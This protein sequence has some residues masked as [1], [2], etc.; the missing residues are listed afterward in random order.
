MKLEHR[1]RF[2]VVLVCFFLSGLAAL[3]Y[4][5]VWSRQFAFVFGTS[6]LA[7]ATVLAAYMAGL[8]VGAAAA[9]RWLRR[10]R[11]PVLVYGVLELGIAVAALLVPLG[12]SLS[13]ALSKAVL[14]GLEDPAAAEGLTMA[15][16]YLA[17]SFAI[18]LLPT[19][20]MGAT[21]PILARSVVERDEQVG[22]RIGTLYAVNTLGAVFGTI[23]AGFFLLP[24]V[25][26]RMT[27]WIGVAVNVLV[28]LV[29]AFGLR[30]PKSASESDA[31]ATKASSPRSG[32]GAGRWVLPLMLMSGVVSF[33][34]E[35]LWTRLLGHILGGSVYAF[36]TMLA[37][38]LVGI[39]VGSAVGSRVATRSEH[40]YRWFSVVQLAIGACAYVAYRMVDHLPDVAVNL[41]A[42]SRAGLFANAALCAVVLL[43]ATLCIGA[44]FP[45]AVRTLART[46]DEAGEASA[47]VYSWNTVGAILGAVGAGFVLLPALG[48]RGAVVA[49]VALNLILAGIA[50]LL[51]AP[52]ANR[53]LV[54]AGVALLALLVVRAETPWKILHYKPLSDVAPT[55]ADARGAN[56]TR[57]AVGRGATVLLLE[58]T[59]EWELR[60]N[61]N[62]EAGILAPGHFT[63]ARSAY[64]LSGL[65]VLARPKTRSMLVIGLGG[66]TL[67]EALPRSLES[68]DVIELE[69]EILEANRALQSRRQIDPLAD[70]R[71]RVFL[72]D[73]RGAL[74]LTT[75]RYDAIV[76]QPS[77]PWTAG[78]AHLYTREFFELAREHLSEDGVLLQWIGAGF[79]DKELLQ[80]LVATLLDVFPNVRA[81]RPSNGPSVL[82]LASAKPLPVERTAAEAIA[83]SPKEFLLRSVRRPEDVGAMLVFDEEGARRFAAGA[84][85]N[86]D[87]E[88]ILQTRSPRILRAPL[89]L[90]GLNRLF[91]TM[92]PFS[93]LSEERV[94]DEWDA[95][96]LH[97]MAML[98]GRKAAALLIASRLSEHE[99]LIVQARGLLRRF[100]G[101]ESARLLGQALTLAPDAYAAK[102]LLARAMKLSKPSVE[103]IRTLEQLVASLPPEAQAVLNGMHRR[104]RGEW[105]AIE[106]SDSDLEAVRVTDPLHDIA[107]RL[108]VLWRLEK[109]DAALASEAL[110]MI[111]EAMPF[112]GSPFPD[113][114]PDALIRIRLF[115]TLGE[116]DTSLSLLR[117]AATAPGRTA[118]AYFR[119]IARLLDVVPPTAERRDGISEVRSVL[120][121]KLAPTR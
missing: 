15:L 119:E 29:A 30:E 101:D 80:S 33:A 26:L 16:F 19:G 95:L 25:G 83:A 109:D 12:V 56:V 113:V 13:V 100:K 114:P 79:V 22:T 9:G 18:L 86:T 67:L 27:V 10:I 97:E 112:A 60:S 8:S 92:D 2:L 4:Q 23:L 69:P 55:E 105:A 87:N 72:N 3:L 118:K 35:I 120:R 98:Y 24:A 74:Q 58:R 45:I 21:L 39:T 40:G 44:T 63:R 17:C 91:S 93:R 36:A 7:I 77:H 73:G 11:R 32:W 94:A 31:L 37:T 107:V 68:I 115:Q 6:E 121:K 61:G 117:V 14:G 108:R 104:S 88:N 62:P 38:V 116:F 102:V 66:G 28:F 82:F 99:K 75:K 64:W 53:L 89:G 50:A 51:S 46:R 47:S 42:G 34:Y 103:S 71:V 20:L 110:A 84:V 90:E 1:Q 5:T 59:G 81:Y 65:P 96:Y 76:S 52:R 111:T 54:P 85:I 70:S 49:A 106:A 48:Y 43:P 41:G 57:F 78:A